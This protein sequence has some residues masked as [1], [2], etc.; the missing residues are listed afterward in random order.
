M[1]HEIRQNDLRKATQEETTFE[2][3]LWLE[4]TNYKSV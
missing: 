4:G 3:I 2:G 1:P